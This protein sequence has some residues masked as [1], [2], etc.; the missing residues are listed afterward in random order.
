MVKIGLELH[1]RLG[2]RHKL[3]C[4]CASVSNDVK[5]GE[6]QRKLHAVVSE[7]GEVDV[8]AKFESDKA[9]P[10]LYDMYDTGS[11]LVEMDDEPPG[12]INRDAIGTVLTIC[13]MIDAEIVD[14]IHVM[15]KT[16]VDGSN[17]SG[18]QRTAIVGLD[19]HIDSDG[20]TI[21][22]QTIALEEESC[23]IVGEMAGKTERFR[24]DRLGIPLIEIATDPT[25][26]SGKEARRVAEKLGLM[27]RATGR[28][29]RGIGTIRQ[30]LNISTEGGARVE[31]KGVQSLDI[32]ETVIDNE[33]SRQTSLIA[34][35]ERI[36]HIKKEELKCVDVTSLFK[37]TGSR[38]IKNAVA[39]G[40]NVIAA[41]FVG[42][43]GV[44]GTELYNNFRYGTELSGYA[45]ASGAG[46]IIHCDEDMN[47]YGF[48][49]EI[50]D[51]MKALELKGDDGWI[52][53]VGKEDV[54]RRAMEAVYARAYLKNVPEETRRADLEGRSHYMRPLPGAARMYP[55]TDVKPVRITENDIKDAASEAISFDDLKKKMQKLLN[56]ELADKMLR[57]ERIELFMELVEEGVEPTL[58]AV[59]LEDTLKTL[60]REGLDTSAINEENI[61]ELFG[62][63]L[64]E[65]IVKAA[66][67]EVLR[68]I[69]KNPGR[70][71]VNIIK[72]R[73]LDRVSGKDLENL[74]EKMKE[75]N[76]G[77]IMT[78]YRLNVD[79]EELKKILSK[80]NKENTP[81]ITGPG[82]K[83]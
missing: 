74:L 60:R 33:L 11:C 43:K 58:A 66:I 59:T 7:L 69:S 65:R 50:N 23:G 3:F 56:P 45:K 81:R 15:R 22:L 51:L 44:F 38:F 14:E 48:G 17:T 26:T 4:N 35:I 28:M 82:K 62:L 6:M 80:G 10:F 13:S 21:G 61:S 20:K 41:R 42:M 34:L 19:G 39:R 40:D 79:P 18:F 76:I 63:Y 31:I 49:K 25:I 53:I 52:A 9:A 64:K 78:K 47:K 75:A 73:G 68:E 29:M 83:K 67:P 54:G 24:L 70:K 37:E 57:S 71:I 12:E 72:E 32:I 36:K 77:T 55:E 5:K 1:Q 16:V 27:M 2:T 30:D 8:A 46:G